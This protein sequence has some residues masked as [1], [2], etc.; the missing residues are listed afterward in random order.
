[1]KILLP[2]VNTVPA[3]ASVEWDIFTLPFV[4]RRMDVLADELERLERDPSVFARAFRTIVARAALEA[5]SADA[6]RLAAVASLDLDRH[7]D[8]DLDLDRD[9]D[10]A[11]TPRRE[12]LEL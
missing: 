7:L 4:R 10:E 5:L 1:M 9:L 2:G 6:S 11:R 3:V 8:L 12:V